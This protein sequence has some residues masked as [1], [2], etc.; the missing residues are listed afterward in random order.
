MRLGPTGQ[1]IM[2]RQEGFDGPTEV[3]G[4]SDHDGPKADSLN[5]RRNLDSGIDP[6]P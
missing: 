5:R 1:A 4:P 3:L 6:E 2:G